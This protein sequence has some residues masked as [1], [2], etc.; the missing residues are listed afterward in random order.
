[1]LWFLILLMYFNSFLR[2][3]LELTTE[4]L[5]HSSVRCDRK[6]SIASCPL[7]FLS[8]NYIIPLPLEDLV[9]RFTRFPCSHSYHTSCLEKWAS[10]VK[11]RSCP[12]CRLQARL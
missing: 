4:K 9:M 8:L 10:C 12:S 6:T 1:M 2:K 7:C 11:R 3:I 5:L